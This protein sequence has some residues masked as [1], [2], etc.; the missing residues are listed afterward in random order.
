M[1]CG[2]HIDEVGLVLALCGEHALAASQFEYRVRQLLDAELDACVRELAGRSP[3]RIER[4]P[5]RPG[6]SRSRGGRDRANRDA[7]LRAPRSAV[8]AALPD[9]VAASAGAQVLAA[10]GRLVAV[11]ARGDRCRDQQ[12]PTAAAR[13][14][15]D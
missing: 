11:A 8:A 10:L 9:A 5:G 15:V 1:I 14:V 13:H 7:P 3:T 6:T 4:S 12:M 2:C